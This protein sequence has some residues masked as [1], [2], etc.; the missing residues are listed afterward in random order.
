MYL[1]SDASYKVRETSSSVGS[2]S[3]LH[4]HNRYTV[5]KKQR[6]CKVGPCP[7]CQNDDYN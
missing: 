7:N 1:L 6:A 4:I 5:G 2:D 3:L